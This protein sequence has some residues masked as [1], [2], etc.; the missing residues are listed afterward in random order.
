MHSKTDEI[1][2]YSQGKKLFEAAPGPKQ[3]LKISGG[4]NDAFLA[5]ESEIEIVVMSFLDD[6]VY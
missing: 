2:P 5:S 3:F 1:I 6:L 4:H